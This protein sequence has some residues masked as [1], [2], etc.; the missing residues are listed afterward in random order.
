MQLPSADEVEYWKSPDK[1]GWLQSQGEHIKNWRKRWFVLKQGYLFRFMNSSVTESTKPRGVVD[2]SKIQDIKPAS[3]V[4]GR[5]NSIQLKTSSGG[6]VSY[7]CDT[8]TEMVEWMSAM[9][10]AVSKIVKHLAGVEDEP[11]PKAPPKKSS[12]PSN[13]WLRQL[14]K[15]FDNLSGGSS[16]TAGTTST[17][18]TGSGKAMVDI[19]GYESM[20]GSANHGNYSSSQYRDSS[21]SYRDSGY[22]GS[23]GYGSGIGYGQI[24]GWSSQTCILLLQPQHAWL[25]VSQSAGG[26]HQ[27]MHAAGTAIALGN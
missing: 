18:A 1:A 14:E 13:E 16:R 19:V 15:N 23:A 5:P 12:E 6:S 20:G 17:S 27:R 26:T 11:A 22:G 9:E 7:I 4:T 25:Y 10:G 3:N 21:S 24:A 2:L 8:E